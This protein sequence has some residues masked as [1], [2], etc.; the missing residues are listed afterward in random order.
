MSGDALSLSGGFTGAFTGSGVARRAEL[1]GQP[2]ILAAAWAA[3]S[4]RFLPVWQSRCLWTGEGPG[5]PAARLGPALPALDRGIYL[6]ERE[7]AALFAL[8]LE[9][10][11]PPAGFADADFIGL[12]DLVSRV[13][14]ADAALLAYARAMV[15]WQ[16]RHRH[17]GVCGAPNRPEHGGFIM[18]CTRADCGHRSFPR[19]DPAV[20]VLVHRDDHCL[21][22]RQ[23]RWPEGRFSTIAGFV[24]PG[25]C[26]E[27]AVAREV[28]E[29]TNIAVGECRYL[30]SQPWPFPAALMLG[31]HARARGAGEIRYN[32]GELAEARWLTRAELAARAVTLPPAESI[33]FRLIEA[34]FDQAPGPKLATLGLASRMYRRPDQPPEFN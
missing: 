14:Q 1:R 20:I 17:C 33:A 4:T 21:L 34:W 28:H 10:D 3:D 19:L 30:G 32:D 5:C 12:R 16:Q 8:A 15:I 31:F 11:S 13:G 9:G 22:G 26:L 27:D 2:E 6:G 25:E 24:E 7:G 23:V 29:E 18:D